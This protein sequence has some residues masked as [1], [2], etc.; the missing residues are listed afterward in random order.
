MKLLTRK[1][2]VSP[3]LAKNPEVMVCGSDNAQDL[4]QN[5]LWPN[6]FVCGP[7]MFENY[8]SEQLLYKLITYAKKK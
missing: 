1:S 5:F 2:H 6:V 3:S 8:W 4:E 7:G